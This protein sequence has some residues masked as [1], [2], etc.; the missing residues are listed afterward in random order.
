MSN[1]TIKEIDS[2]FN[3]SNHLGLPWKLHSLGDDRWEL[4]D[5]DGLIIFDLSLHKDSNI[6]S[7]QLSSAKQGIENGLYWLKYVWLDNT[8]YKNELENVRTEVREVGNLINILSTSL[9][10]ALDEG[11]VI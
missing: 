5:K 2:F 1:N 11:D 9:D 10:S 4:Y 6:T 7:S 8:S 3:N